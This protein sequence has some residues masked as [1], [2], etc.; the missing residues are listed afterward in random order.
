MFGIRSP[1]CSKLA[2]NP[3]K[4]NNDVTISRHDVNV[5]SLWN[6]FVS[7]V[8]FSY[9]SK[10]HVNIITGSGIMAIFFYKG[11]PEIWKSE[12]PPSKFCPISG[13]WGELWIPNL[14]WMSLIEC[15]WQ[16]EYGRKCKSIICATQLGGC[17]LLKMF[18]KF[19]EFCHSQKT[20]EYWLVH[21][22]KLS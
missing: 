14:A 11:W 9:W 16:R 3:K 22:T 15:Y 4:Q 7:L 2:K 17:V 10:F 13:D 1:D 6:C 18:W 5:K 19:F 21:A 8:K 12:I 20:V